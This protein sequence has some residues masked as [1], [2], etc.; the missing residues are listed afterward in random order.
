MNCYSTIESIKSNGT[1]C[2][3]VGYSKI[4][5]IRNVY[6]NTVCNASK[7]GV[8]VANDKKAG[9]VWKV[10]TG[11]LLT[12]EQMKDGPVAV[13]STGETAVSFAEALSKG[14]EEF[15]AMSKDILPT[16]P[17]VALRHWEMSASYP[18]FKLSL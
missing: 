5:N 1:Y 10:T 13:A 15:A 8:V 6:G 18:V 11:S 17:D 2:S 4:G 7:A 16:K 3:A 14:A 9:T 12:L